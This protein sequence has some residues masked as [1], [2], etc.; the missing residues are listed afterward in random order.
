MI[1]SLPDLSRL[2]TFLLVLV[3]SLATF[4]LV[5]LVGLDSLPLVSGGTLVFGFC[6]SGLGGHM[7]TLPDVSKLPVGC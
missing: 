7:T 4:T 3:P 5:T 6:L 1:L 2:E